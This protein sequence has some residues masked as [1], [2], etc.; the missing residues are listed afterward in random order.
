LAVP[1]YL[2]IGPDGLLYIS[3]SSVRRIRKVDANGII[4]NVAGGGPLTNNLAE[5]ISATNAFLFG[6]SGGRLPIA[7][8]PDGSLYIATE[9]RIR[10]VRR[11]GLIRT[12]A[13]IGGFSAETPDGN[14]A[15]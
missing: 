2:A 15:M 14:S 5:E 10:Q 12:I 1:E 4:R 6:E 7:F 8:G 3:D 11:D 9:Q 13:G